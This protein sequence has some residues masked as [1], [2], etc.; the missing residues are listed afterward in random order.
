MGILNSSHRKPN[1]PLNNLFKALLKPHVSG[2]GTRTVADN[3]PLCWITSSLTHSP[4]VQQ[5]IR[6]TD[7]GSWS[8]S[9]NTKEPVCWDEMNEINHQ[10]GSVC[11]A[12][13]LSFNVPDIPD[14]TLFAKQP[15]PTACLAWRPPCPT[16]RKINTLWQY[17]YYNVTIKTVVHFSCQGHVLQL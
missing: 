16:N 9:R 3:H 10:E 2:W 14:H 6:S 5:L 8:I 15:P 7:R 4:S 1:V 12:G 17:G 11:M 13:K